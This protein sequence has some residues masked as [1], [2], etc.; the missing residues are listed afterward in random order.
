VDGELHNDTRQR[1]SAPY[2]QRMC[3]DL[4]TKEWMWAVYAAAAVPAGN[5][6]LIGV[7]LCGSE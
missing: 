2:K 7:Y 3:G 5:G 4:L 6:L 1:V